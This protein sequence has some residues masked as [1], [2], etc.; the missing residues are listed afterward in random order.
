MIGMDILDTLRMLEPVEFLDFVLS[1]IL[2]IFIFFT[3]FIFSIIS[4]VEHSLYILVSLLSHQIRICSLNRFV[5]EYLCKDIKGTDMDHLRI[6]FVDPKEYGF[7]PQ[8]LDGN[9]REIVCAR[10]GFLAYQVESAQ[11]IHYFE[12]YG[13]NGCIM[14][15]RFWIGNATVDST[16]PP[17]LRWIIGMLFSIPFM[18]K[19]M[20]PPDTGTRILTH[21]AK[22]MN[23]LATFLPEVYQLYMNEK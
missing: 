22:E 13:D 8:M 10:A 2:C 14:K 5:Y 16:V 11:F 7:T 21:C 9:E 19:V 6:H 15:S 18:R 20:I 3:F 23:C 17:P 1:P 12:K 4:S